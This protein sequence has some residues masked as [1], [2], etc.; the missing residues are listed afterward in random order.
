[1]TT[2]ATPPKATAALERELASVCRK[3]DEA[4][5]L[6]DRRVHLFIDLRAAGVTQA[7]I[8]EV[9]SMSDVG[10]VLAIKRHGE[11]QAKL[12]QKIADARDDFERDSLRAERCAFCAQGA[13][14]DVS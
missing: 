4:A 6:S 2:T 5:K 7:R 12:E 13:A 14:V 1:M 3:I 10:V 11:R 8:G 9:A